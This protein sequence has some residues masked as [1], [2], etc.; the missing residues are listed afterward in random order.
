MQTTG[1][2]EK[3]DKESPQPSRPVRIALIT[4]AVIVVAGAWVY[5][6]VVGYIL[7][8]AL[9]IFLTARLGKKPPT[10]K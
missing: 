9:L 5:N 10:T 8:L 4:L 1:R 7:G 6:P 2:E 3:Q